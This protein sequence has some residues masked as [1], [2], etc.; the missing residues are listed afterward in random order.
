[1]VLALNSLES[2]WRNKIEIHETVKE[3]ILK[4]H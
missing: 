1:M 3:F 2:C 4:L